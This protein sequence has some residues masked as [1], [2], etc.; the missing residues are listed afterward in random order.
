MRALLSIL[1]SGCLLFNSMVPAFAGIRPPKRSKNAAKITQH[2][3][4]KY[5]KDS[6]I[7]EITYKKGFTPK[8]SI[9]KTPAKSLVDII[10][11]DPKELAKL[12]KLV[13]TPKLS[14]ALEFSFARAKREAIPDAK[15]ILEKTRVSERDWLLRRYFAL[16]VLT[17]QEPLSRIRK[18]IEL[19]KEDLDNNGSVLHNLPHESL[20]RFLTRKDTQ[21]ALDVIAAASS[22]A[23]I[24]TQ[25]DI[26]ALLHFYNQAV[27]S[28]LAPL[29]QVI[30]ARGLLHMGA[31]ESFNNWVKDVETAGEFW[32][33]LAE[34]AREDNL[35]ISFEPK[36]AGQEVDAAELEYWLRQAGPL[37]RAHAFPSR[38]VTRLWPFVAG[39]DGAFRELLDT[40]T[41]DKTKKP[42]VAAD[43]ET[44]LHEASQIK[45]VSN[46]LLDYMQEV[47]SAD[48]VEGVTDQ[49]VVD[50][51]KDG[52][53]M[54]LEENGK[55]QILPVSLR[56]SNRFL[57]RNWD[58]FWANHSES[59]YNRVVVKPEPRLKKGDY[60]LEMRNKTR[61]PSKMDHF[62]FRLQE[63]QVGL[64]VDMLNRAG[65]EKFFLKLESN[66]KKFYKYV[67]LPVYREGTMKTTPLM[68]SIPEKQYKKGDKLIL[69]KNGGLGWL[70]T[71]VGKVVPVRN[72]Y[73]RLPK[74]Q[75]T[76]LVK[77]LKAFP[78]D[79]SKKLNLSLRSTKN[80][81]NFISTAVSMSNLSLG[82]TFGPMVRGPLD[83]SEQAATDMMFGINYVLP[84]FASLL[85][86]M[87]KKYG[88]RK[89]MTISVGLSLASGL[90]ATAGGFY[91]AVTGMTLGPVQKGLFVAA[92]LSMSISSILSALTG[93]K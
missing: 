18:G 80:G 31:Y 65:V 39:E 68:V 19:L 34:L 78:E 87:L 48:E 84:G 20:D 45:T 61:T 46:E 44:K 71:E 15:S 14:H 66:P 59:P 51:A 88:E 13:Q 90:L 42:L 29:A 26:P 4:S 49:R 67:D 43:E 11:E 41:L 52:F 2:A 3:S 83:I 35:P 60:E 93:A 76:E 47:S 33:E 36:P 37:H 53:L 86:P 6:R 58:S 50:F 30:T 91:G 5:R 54:T 70:S 57:N 24:G 23:A 92:L 17:H 72:L 28:P 77:V 69:L 75:M 74:H 8:N 64:L 32:Q 89:M 38:E 27:H 56:I 1:L 9:P 12:R 85:T 10:Y 16:A 73:V 21:D 82:K 63:N 25:E 22:L 40:E 62:Y 79:G 7:K 81:A 55:E